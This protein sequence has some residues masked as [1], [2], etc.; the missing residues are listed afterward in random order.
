MKSEVKTTS[1]VALVS[2]GLATAF[3]L[4][5]CC[6]IPILLAGVGVGTGWLGPLVA[7]SQPYANILT[8]ISV[9]ALLA[10]MAIVIRAPKHCEPGS[11]CA[12]PAFRWSIIAL[13]LA[14]AVLLIL[15]K[16]YA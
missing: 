1:A 2:G 13:A 6:A 11:L 12:R 9:V 3:A 4:A 7:V 5:A 16:M 8:A 15:S 14:G 10:S